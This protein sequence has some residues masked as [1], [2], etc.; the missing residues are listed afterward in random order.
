M[1]LIVSVDADAA[2]SAAIKRTQAAE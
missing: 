1:K 2:K